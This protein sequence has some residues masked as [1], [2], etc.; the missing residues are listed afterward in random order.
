MFSHHGTWVPKHGGNQTDLYLYSLVSNKEN[1]NC[2]TRDLANVL[3][4]K[5]TLK[6][7][8]CHFGPDFYLSPFPKQ[9]N[10]VYFSEQEKRRLPG[11]LVFNTKVLDRVHPEVHSVGERSPQQQAASKPQV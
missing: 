4:R 10:Q 6:S 11:P 7:A 2:K 5:L 3:S 9:T 1:S 8:D